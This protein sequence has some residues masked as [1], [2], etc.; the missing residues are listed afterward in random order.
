MMVTVLRSVRADFAPEIWAGMQTTVDPDVFA[1][2]ELAV[3]ACVLLLNGSA[4][5]IRDN[6]RAFFAAVALGIGGAALVL[7]LAVIGLRANFLSPFAFMVM[8]H[9]L[10]LYLPYLVVHTTIFERL[11]AM[12][13]DRGNIGYLMYLRRGSVGYL[14]FKRG[15]PA[16]AQC[17]VRPRQRVVSPVLPHAQLQVLAGAVWFCSV[18]C[19]LYFGNHPATRAA[20]TPRIGLTR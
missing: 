13:R 10:G 15:G 12:T 18:P 9:G 5:F 7:L 6:R 2:S 19:G 14:G 4:V 8:Q 1:R 11:I 16:R 17:T 20:A 3:A